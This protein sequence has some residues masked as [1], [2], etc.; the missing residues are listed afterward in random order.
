MSRPSA[1]VPLAVTERSGLDESVHF[2]SVVVLGADGSIVFSAGDPTTT[3]YPRSSNKPMQAVAMV[4]AG[5]DLPPD[6]LALVCASHDGT[7]EHLAAARHILAGAGLD[8]LALGNTPG[9]PLDEHAAH[10][11][12]RHGGGRTPLQMNCSG[13]HAGMLATCVVN[14]WPH[15]HSYLDAQHPLQRHITA[16]I[17]ELIGTPVD[18]VGVDGCGAPAH[19]MSLVALATGFAA[20]AAGRAGAAGDAV[21]R[22]MTAHPDMVGG[23]RRD[24][25]AFI[26]HV[27][28]LIAKDGAEGVFAA[29]LPDGRAVALKIADGSDR[30]RAPVMMSALERA[31]VDTSEVAPI[32]VQHIRGHD[33]SVG[34]VRSLLDGHGAR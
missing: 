26:R 15:D 17:D 9:L 22:A 20:I 34:V 27:P 4:R 31:G 7:P 14:G 29:A 10:T 1:F 12:L 32:V 19:A 13:K 18:H 25:T 3:V 23:E 28:G 6:Q 33:R 11:V 5:L 8:E 2:G 24:V 21:R 30:A 16:T